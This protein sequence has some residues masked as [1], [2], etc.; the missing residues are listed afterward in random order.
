MGSPGIGQFVT[1]CGGGVWVNSHTSCPFAQNVHEQGMSQAGGSS[2]LIE[3]YSP[4]TGQTYTM[5]CVRAADNSVTCIGGN[6]A[7]GWFQV[8]WHL[9]DDVPPAEI[10]PPA[11]GR[12]SRAAVRRA[13][14]AG[15]HLT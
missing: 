11:P 8:E 12:A 14:R 2:A 9:A 6:G 5:A 4:D 15:M 1:D 13:G 3:A 7:A 10:S